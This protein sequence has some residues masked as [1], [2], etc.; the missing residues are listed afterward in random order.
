MKKLLFPLILVFGFFLLPFSSIFAQAPDGVNYQAVV[1]SSLGLP[2]NSQAVD[3]RFTI[4]QGSST[5]TAVF[6]EIHNTTTNQFGL[7]NLELGSVNNGAFSAINWGTG[8]AYYLQI[9]V[10][11]GAGYDNLGASQLLS[12]P[13]ALFARS[14][15]VGV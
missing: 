15:V 5:G 6:T 7:I 12:V 3:V 11:A 13:Y 2:L 9:E 1:R 4:H 10:D 8:G 14:V